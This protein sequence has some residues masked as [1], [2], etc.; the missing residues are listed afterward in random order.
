MFSQYETPSRCLWVG[1][2]LTA[3]SACSGSGDD[4]DD[5]ASPTPTPTVTPAPA[6]TW[7]GDVKPLVD[8]V[9]ANCHVEGGVGPTV[10]T[11]YETASARATT[12]AA[13]VTSGYMPPKSA[14]P[15]CREYQ[16]SERHTLS[17]EEK[18]LFQQWA[19][20]GAPKGDPANATD[21]EP[22]EVGLPNANLVVTIP[23][24]HSPTFDESGNE[25]YCYVVDQGREQTVFLDGFDTL[26]DRPEIVHHIVLYKGT[27]GDETPP[28]DALTD[29]WECMHSS[30]GDW[31]MIAAWA[32]GGGPII[33][34]EGY[35]I[36]LEPNEMLAIQM[37][38]FKSS[39][40]A[41]LLTDQSGY[42]LRTRTSA[43][44]EAYYLGF[45]E[46][47]FVIPAGDSNYAY[48]T[49]FVM[50][51]GYGN[52]KIFGVFPHMHVL[53]KRF[54]YTVSRGRGD[55]ECILAGEYDFHNQLTYMLREPYEVKPGDTITF[56]CTWD[57]SAGN[58]NQQFSPPVDI[59]Y[60]EGTQDEM[61]FGFTIAS[62][63]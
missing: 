4:D 59:T 28:E 34:P 26:V 37:H 22:F 46:A 50:P 31:S 7:Y 49:T 27:W 16:Y 21:V 18:A 1:L 44:K 15:S 30:P 9:C 13:Y 5:S 45:G 61:C 53:G 40:N 58:P 38:Y 8:R 17:P 33:L 51:P 36:R 3:L 29:G 57:N 20:L 25:Y 62:L 63:E 52:L 55:S 24:Q 23:R 11:D 32:P 35:G 12:L 19:D 14:D 48:D 2:M 39:E 56:T 10:F 54:D 47:D 42:Q 6:V 60:G 43:D 41:A